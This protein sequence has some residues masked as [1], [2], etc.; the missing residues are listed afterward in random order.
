MADVDIDPFEDHDRT[1][2]RT[3]EPTDEHIIGESTWEPDQ[4]C[5]SAERCEQKTSF[6]GTSRTSVLHKEYL[7]GE[8]YK[9]IGN[10]IY[11]K[12]EPNFHL[13]L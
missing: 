2:S 8:I 7:A 9:L 5:V 13:I 12:L 6:R 10:K 11:Q 1:E 4:S 3:N